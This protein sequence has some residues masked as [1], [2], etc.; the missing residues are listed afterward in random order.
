MFTRIS[1][2][3][4]SEA[5]ALCAYKKFL[6]ETIV[7]RDIGAQ[8]TCHMLLK[9]PLVVCS[10]KFFPLNV[11]RK[12]FQRLSTDPHKFSSHNGFVDVYRNHP[13]FLEHLSM[14]ETTRSWT[15]SAHR[16]REQWKPTD[17]HAIVRV[18][19]RFYSIPKEDLDEFETFCFTELLL[20][21]PFRN[22]S[23]DIG[24]LMETIIEN[25]RNFRY[26]PWHIDRAPSSS[27]VIEDDADLHAK[28]TNVDE[29]I[30]EWQLLS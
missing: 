10:R 13:D 17:M 2:A 12:I 19:P 28:P 3:T 7:D 26:R 29:D 21:K 18:W 11:R 14:I 16:K 22:I 23:S 5:H 20:Y 8:E 6:A 1:N 25:W 9:L 24:L 30:E 15:F 27:N 4:A